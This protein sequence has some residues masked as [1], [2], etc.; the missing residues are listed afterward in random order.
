MTSERRIVATVIV[1][2]LIDL[3]AFTIILP[4]FPRLLNYYR[5]HEGGQKVLWSL[6]WMNHLQLAH[7]LRKTGYS[8]R[9]CIAGHGAV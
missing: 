9:I 7:S 1:A 4:L 3:L 5:Q 8:T 2:L 6:G